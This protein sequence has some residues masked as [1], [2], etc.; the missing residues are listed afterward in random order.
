[1]STAPNPDIHT[2]VRLTKFFLVVSVFLIVISILAIYSTVAATEYGAKKDETQIASLTHLLKSMDWLNYYDARLIAETVLQAQIDNLN[3]ILQN[4]NSNHTNINNNNSL[5][6]IVN[7][8][9]AN[10][11]TIYNPLTRY[12]S[13]VLHGGM[14]HADRSVEGSLANLRYNAEVENSTYEKSLITI[15]ETSKFITIYELVT[16]LLIIGAGLCGIS[17][18]A[19]NKLLGYPGFAVGGVGVTIL[20]LVILDPSTMVGSQGMFH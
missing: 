9:A 4:V 6:S 18:I 12:E 16:I 20:L 2:D 19:K 11:K 1:M 15:S 14:L 13:E 3:I 8:S 7:N 10:K 17:E 5:T